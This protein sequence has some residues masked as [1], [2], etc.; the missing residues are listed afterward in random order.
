MVRINWFV[1]VLLSVIAAVSSAA[2]PATRTNSSI[3]VSFAPTGPS[4][5]DF[6]AIG[7]GKA[8]DT[9]AIEAAVK[10]GTGVLY[11]P[12]GKYRL[13]RTVRIDLNAT[14]ML[15]LIG[16]GGACVIMAGAGPAFHFLGTHDGTGD[17]GSV[18]DEIWQRQRLPI[19]TGIE[20]RGAHAESVGLRLEKTMQATLTNLL[21]RR[22]KIGIHLV[23]R[24]RNLI[25][26]HCHIYHNTHVGIDFDKVNLH[27]AIIADSH[28]SYNRVA[29]IRLLG[30]QMR[31]F[32]IVGNDIEYNYDTKL[33]GSADILIDMTPEA[34]SFREGTIIGNT[35][36]ARP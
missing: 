6:G 23:K 1:V 27:Q 7:D 26:D 34:S 4:V 33:E 22:C 30:G 14:G 12:K 13:A 10:A 35:I 18:R 2:S 20:I 32:Q 17:P 15:S 24:N 16:T 8:D 28:I 25:I 21:I 29:G 36:Q 19:I 31:N 5:R 11:F 3:S 9:A